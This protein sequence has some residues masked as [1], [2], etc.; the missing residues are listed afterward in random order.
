MKK[1]ELRDCSRLRE[2]GENQSLSPQG[3]C[4]NT[5]ASLR[6]SFVDS[7]GE[8]AWG[9]ARGE[10]YLTMMTGQLCKEDIFYYLLVTHL[11]G[12]NVRRRHSR[13]FGNDYFKL[14]CT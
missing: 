14:T 10:T 11:M 5:I 13:Q 12:R 8:G 7:F 9:L 1:R 3:S 2:T 4:G 6:Q